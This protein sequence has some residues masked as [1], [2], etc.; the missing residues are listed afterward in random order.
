MPLRISMDWLREYIELPESAADLADRLTLSGTEVERVVTLGSGWDGVVV[1]RAIEVTDIPGADHIKRAV[2][3]AGDRRAELVSGAPNLRQGDLLAWAQPGTTLPN[4]MTIAE[5]RF[6]GVTSQGVL[7][8]P[9]ELGIS[10]EADG[11]LVLGTDGPTGMPLADLMPPDEVMVIEVT[12]NRPDLLCHLGIA[13]E[14][15]ALLRR[16]LK[17]PMPAPEE[18][19]EPS[20]LTVEI[21]EPELCARYQA[22]YLYGARVGP[23]PA[24]MQRRLRAVGQK[25]ISNVVD[26]AN[27]VMFETG[28]PLHAFDAARLDRGIVVRRA[29]AGEE[30]ACLDGRTRHLAEDD[31]V[32]ADRSVAVAIAGIIG[33][34]DSAVSAETTRLLLESANFNGVSV[35]N[36]SRR[37]ALRT[38]ASTRFEKQLS[39][40]LTAPAVTRLAELLQQVAGAGPSTA[41]LDVNPGATDAEVIAVAAGYVGTLLG[42]EVADSEVTDTLEALEFQVRSTAEGGLE[43]VQPPFRRDVRGAVDLVEEVGRMRGYNTLPSTL[44]GRRVEVREILPPPDVEWQAREIAAGAGHDEVINSSFCGPADPEVGIF[45]TPRLALSNPMSRDQAQMRTS[46]LWGLAR[47][48]SRNV[49]WGNNGVAVFELGHVF[50]PREGQELPREP[51]SLG[52]AVHLAPGRATSDAGTRSALLSLKGL[53][54]VVAE[55]VSGVVLEHRQDQVPGLHPGRSARVSVGGTEIGCFGELHPDLAHRLDVPGSVVLGEIDFEALAGIPRQIRYHAP[56]RF[57][58]VVRDLAISVPDLTPARDVVEA[59]SGAG[60]VIL[61]TVDLFDEYHGTQVDGG[62]KGLAFRLV[63]QADDRTLTGEEVASAEERIAG[64]LR[65][66]FAATMRA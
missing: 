5:R 19:T 32:I 11:L 16:P 8:S 50:W 46:L 31:L 29:R 37:L 18:S 58:A 45:P 43:V 44:P 13:R 25:P 10:S 61:R 54:D 23:S 22:R 7:C 28:Q 63:F 4:G 59:L 30:I 15:S 65:D 24:W 55:E 20:P 49:A 2:V 12:T 14:L 35:R 57:P 64:L 66:R 62:R 33:G 34:A 27:Y 36:S 9:V 38:E 47:T 40:E 6:K 3:E 39:P 51:R 56:S 41:A 1:V 53:I 21:A 26:A 42:I 48:V 17:A 52:L 60:E